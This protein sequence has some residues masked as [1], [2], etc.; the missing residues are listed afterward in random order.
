VGEGQRHAVAVVLVFEAVGRVVVIDVAVL[1]RKIE[2]GRIVGKVE[3][4]VALIY[5]K[6]TVGPQLP[7][8]IVSSPIT[9]AYTNATYTPESRIHAGGGGGPQ[10]LEL[11]VG[12][13]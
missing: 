6:I 2:I 11:R 7:P 4:S 10:C 1:G 9:P 12:D 13:P 5:Y 8:N 3:Q